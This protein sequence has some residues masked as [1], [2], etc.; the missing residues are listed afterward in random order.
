MAKARL[1]FFPGHRCHSYIVRDRV[2]IYIFEDTMTA[3]LADMWFLEGG[4][5][6]I[7]IGSNNCTLE[8]G[9][10]VGG[11]FMCGEST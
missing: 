10:R 11:V 7:R 9:V 2:A 1:S 3:G 6:L 5:Q 8:L 4:Q